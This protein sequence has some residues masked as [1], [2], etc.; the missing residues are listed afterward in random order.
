MGPIWRVISLSPLAVCSIFVRLGTEMSLLD[1]GKAGKESGTRV[2]RSETTTA[3][4]MKSWANAIGLCSFS[5][6]L[7]AMKDRIINAMP[8]TKIQGNHAGI[9]E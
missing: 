6:Y 2:P 4:P 7:E 5:W 3:P 9:I 8:P 1:T